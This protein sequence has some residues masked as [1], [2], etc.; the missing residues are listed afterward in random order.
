ME[1]LPANR[2]SRWQRVEQ[3]KQHLWRRWMKEYLHS[4]QSRVKW[5][6]SESPVKIRQMVILKEENLPPMCWALARVEEVFPGPDGIV[7]VV[8]VR[9]TKGIYKRPITKLCILPFE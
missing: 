7:R 3:L 1:C 4:C 2:L 5:K 6:T 8:S 9:T